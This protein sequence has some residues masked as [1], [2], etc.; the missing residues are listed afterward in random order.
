MFKNDIETMLHDKILAL[1]L[2][3]LSQFTQAF[4]LTFIQIDHS[5]TPE[6]NSCTF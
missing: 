5:L 4:S 6:T 3:S 1:H 2:V